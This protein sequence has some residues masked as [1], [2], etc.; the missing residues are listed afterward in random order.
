MKNIYI[1]LSIFLLS[2]SSTFA[3]VVM[4]C[5]AEATIHEIITQ[6]TF[7]RSGEIVVL[8]NKSIKKCL[9][10]PLANPDLDRVS[11][12]I[13][14]ID[15]NNV[16]DIFPQSNVEVISQCGSSMGS[17]GKAIEFNVWYLKGVLS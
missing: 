11:I 10:V 12:D 1:L 7:D 6:P 8:L 14:W 9:C 17:E 4:D 2:S 15:K 3:S 16:V 5:K 13:K